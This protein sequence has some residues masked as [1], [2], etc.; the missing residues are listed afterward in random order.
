MFFFACLC[1]YSPSVSLYSASDHNEN[2]VYLDLYYAT[3]DTVSLD[4]EFLDAFDFILRKKGTFR[5]CYKIELVVT[6]A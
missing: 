3:S 1:Q 4:V 2:K 5:D 6:V